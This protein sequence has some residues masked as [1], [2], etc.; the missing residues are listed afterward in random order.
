MH[1]AN[2]VLVLA[3]MDIQHSVEGGRSVVQHIL[4]IKSASRSN[5][6]DYTLFITVGIDDTTLH[7]ILHTINSGIETGRPSTGPRDF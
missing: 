6:R 3:D 2:F 5:Y 4:M 1:F 7:R